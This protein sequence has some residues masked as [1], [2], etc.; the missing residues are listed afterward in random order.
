MDK[1]LN[2][3]LSKEII[4]SELPNIKE[5]MKAARFD[6]MNE[7]SSGICLQFLYK[8][9]R[10]ETIKKGRKRK[11]EKMKERENGEGFQKEEMGTDGWTDRRTD[12]QTDR[13]WYTWAC[14]APKNGLVNNIKLDA[15]I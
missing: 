13:R 5:T 9:D 15:T 12:G 3:K 4:I 1:L 7:I 8:K 14:Y 2:K 10:M 6:P 11:K